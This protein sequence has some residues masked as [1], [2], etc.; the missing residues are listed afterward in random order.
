MKKLFTLS[1]FALLLSFVSFASITGPLGVCVGAS[2]YFTD[3]AALGGAWSSSNPAIATINSST[4]YVTGVAAGTVTITYTIGS[5]YETTTMAVSPAPAPITG[6]GSV[7]SGATLTL[8]DAVSGGTWG[9]YA[10]WIA[11][12]Y[13]TTGV[14][15]GG[16]AGV[17]TVY[18]TTGPECSVTADVTVNITPVAAISGDTGVCVGTTTVLTDATPGGMW[19]SSDPGV[20][21]ISTSGVV[22]GISVGWTEISYSVS[23]SCG[24]ATATTVMMVNGP[25]IAGT[26][27][28]ASTVYVGNSIPLSGTYYGGTW[29]SSD[30][31]TATIDPY[32]GYVT[33]V[34]VGTVTITYT[35]SGCTGTAY[36]TFVLSVIPYNIISGHVLFTGVPY[37]GMVKV[38]LIKYNPA[39]LDLQAVDSTIAY[40]GGS[41]ADYEFLGASTDSFRIKAATPDT[42]VATTGYMPTY[43]N[44]S[45]YWHAATVLYHLTGT[46]DLNQDITMVYGT[47]AAGPGFISGNVTTGANKGTSGGVPVTGMKVFAVNSLTGAV[48][49]EIRTDA[50]GYYA[51]SNLPVGQTYTIFPDSL[52]YLTTAYTSIT[53]TAATPSYSGAGFI[54]HTLSK[55]ITPQP[56]AISTANLTDVSLVAFPNPVSSKLNIQWQLPAEEAGSL[57]LTDVTGR[58]VYTCDLQLTAGANTRYVDVSGLHNGLYLINIKSASFNYNNKI[59]VKH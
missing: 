34:A 18:Y 33:G 30:P 54:Q 16:S 49:Q 8:A 12:V 13:P 46:T 37:Y 41:A 38:W 3:S 59:Q 53:L 31:A 9:S 6:F 50:T 26:I 7:C 10:G 29:S 27:T 22:T 51:F 17:A 45:F 23:G 1:V 56:L 47:V 52:N 15:T 40:S 25:T 55:T 19:A 36:S 4:G 11:D 2:S 58:V 5:T 24:M 44:S 32:S 48:A 14:V 21:T 43:H 42:T 20:A 39:T 28:G 35:V 57:I